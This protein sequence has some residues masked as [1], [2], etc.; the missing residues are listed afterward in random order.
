[1]L[2]GVK[3]K[4]ILMLVGHQRI[5]NYFDKLVARDSLAHAYLFTGPD[6]VGKA[7][8]AKILAAQIFCQEEK[9]PC[10]KCAPCRLIQANTHPDFIEIKQIIEKD[11]DKVRKQKIS[12]E[13]IRDLQKKLSLFPF[14][15]TKKIALIEDAQEISLPAANAL[16]KTLEEPPSQTVLI[17]STSLP[18]ALL[19]TIVSRCQI[20]NFGLFSQGEMK[21]F[22]QLLPDF[23]KLSLLERELFLSLGGGRPGFLTTF[24]KDA[25][26]RSHLLEQT[27]FFKN[28]FELSLPERFVQAKKLAGNQEKLDWALFVWFSLSQ[29]FFRKVNGLLQL[30]E[31][32]KL[33]P[34]NKN[35]ARVFDFS[36]SLQQALY[37]LRDAGFNQRLILENL[38]LKT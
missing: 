2:K 24:L 27:K 30:K 28:I 29:C 3:I 23:K 34:E 21:E 37:S 26:L 8:F 14:S 10:E 19:P 36:R 13:Q 25:N 9:K 4:K 15:A 22:S 16:L 33:L 18:Q 17:L 1:M 32:T 38:F 7:F 11:K 5:K 6:G 31:L 20:I 35:F 12:I